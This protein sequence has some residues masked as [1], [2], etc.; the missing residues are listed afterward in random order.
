MKNSNIL[1]IEDNESEVVLLEE[2]FSEAS[3]QYRVLTLKD[4]EEAKNFLLN[5]DNIKEF[6]PKVILLDINLPKVSGRD[7]LKIIKE[8]CLLRKTVTIVFSTS[9]APSDI[10]YC[11]KNNANAYV[12]KPSDF[13]GLLNFVKNIFSFWINMTPD[14]FWLGGNG[15]Y[16]C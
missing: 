7:L 14:P 5:Q 15:N 9:E 2:A 11:M 6:Q 16:A 3:I 8:D 4:G 10:E 1:L 13:D 12:V